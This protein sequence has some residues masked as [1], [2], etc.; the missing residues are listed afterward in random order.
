MV[1]LLLRKI[2]QR[3]RNNNTRVGRDTHPFLFK[4]EHMK[5]KKVSKKVFTTKELDAAYEA[6]TSL[7][8]GGECGE[9]L[10]EPL[11]S[12]WDKVQKIQYP[13]NK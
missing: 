13:T 7:I 8:E 1:D 11:E 3:K 6:I 9:T 2:S 4:G 12:F 10:A 5:N